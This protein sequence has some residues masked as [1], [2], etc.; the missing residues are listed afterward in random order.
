MPSMLSFSRSEPVRASNAGIA[1]Q[2]LLPSFLAMRQT[3]MKRT[4][5]LTPVFH[6]ILLHCII[7]YAWIA[8]TA[9]S[10]SGDWMTMLSLVEEACD[11]WRIILV[12]ASS[13][14]DLSSARGSVHPQV[15]TTASGG[16][17]KPPPGTSSLSGSK[18][19]LP[20]LQHSRQKYLDRLTLL[21]LLLM[22]FPYC[23]GTG[24]CLFVIWSSRAL[25]EPLQTLSLSF[26]DSWTS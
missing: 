4:L 11:P 8:N 24:A 25:L 19:Y 20:R 13:W 6:Q 17:S 1:A 23:F 26:M 7:C 21:F 3:R 5:P 14:S 15:T 18:L 16:S 22:N 10:V 12:L 2:T 9:T